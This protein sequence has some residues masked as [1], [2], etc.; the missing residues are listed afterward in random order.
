MATKTAKK[1]TATKAAAAKAA[2]STAKPAKRPVKAT[3][4]K[5][6]PAK[7]AAKRSTA[8]KTVAVKKP[9]VKKP[10]V[11]KPMVKKTTPA[12]KI[13]AKKGAPVKT[14][15]AKTPAPATA[16]KKVPAKKAAP[17]SPPPRKLG[18]FACDDYVVYPTHGVG[19][20]S[21]IEDQEIAGFDLRLFVVR[22]EKEKMTLRIP[23]DK[24]EEAGLRK[25]ASRQQIET[26]MDTLRGRSRVSRAMWSR[27]AQEY[28]AKINSGNPISI[29]EVVRDLHRN[30]GQPDQSYSERQIYEA[31][32][33]RLSR[34]VAAVEKIDSA[35]ATVKLEEVLERV[36]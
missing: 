34:E 33:E 15:A 23:V 11:K 24:A 18:N 29:A 22:F 7:T 31:A 16:A 8:A 21:A 4:S 1:T 9:A 2:K 19:Q 13:V 12:T 28:E 26:A 25:L 20:I 14:V 27:R 17:K 30:A 32:L 6:T 35:A 3:K 36:A 10:A 5:A